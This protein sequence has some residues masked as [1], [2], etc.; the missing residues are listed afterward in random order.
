ML[1]KQRGGREVALS[2][3]SSFSCLWITPLTKVETVDLHRSWG[4][5]G[6]RRAGRVEQACPL[7]GV[8]KTG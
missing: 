6:I 5:W 3:L 4:F 2:R 1:P 8:R 7:A